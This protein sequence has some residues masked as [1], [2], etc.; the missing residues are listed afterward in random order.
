MLAKKRID[1]RRGLDAEADAVRAV[2]EVVVVEQVAA[3]EPGVVGCDPAIHQADVRGGAV[4]FVVHA[5]LREQVV[6][7]VVAAVERPDRLQVDVDA[8]FRAEGDAAFDALEE[9]VGGLLERA[10]AAGNGSVGDVAVNW[11]VALVLVVLVLLDEVLAADC[12]ALI[13]LLVSA[14]VVSFALFGPSPPPPMSGSLSC[15]FLRLRARVGFDDG[16]VP[17][18]LAPFFFSSSS[19][20]A[21]GLANENMIA[22]AIDF[23]RKVKRFGLCD[24]LVIPR[25]GTSSSH[26]AAIDPRGNKMRGRN[27]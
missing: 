6:P 13:A 22:M 10:D 20:S 7:L 11:S 8:A 9:L 4:A 23:A 21:A 18:G 16:G 19:A 1:V 15:T 27:F 14:S 17:R 5:E 3:E 24:W 26:W 12:A 2:V 25:K